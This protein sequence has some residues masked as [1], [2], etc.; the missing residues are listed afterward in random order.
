MATG[1]FVGKGFTGG[2]MVVESMQRSLLRN[3]SEEFTQRGAKKGLGHL[4]SELEKKHPNGEL[5]TS[6]L[7]AYV[8]RLAYERDSDSIDTVIN[9]LER[10]NFMETIIWSRMKRYLTGMTPAYYTE[11]MMKKFS[12]FGLMIEDDDRFDLN[13]L[14][15]RKLKLS[16]NLD[17]PGAIYGNWFKIKHAQ[18]YTYKDLAGLEV[19]SNVVF[20]GKIWGGK[21]FEGMEGLFSM[22]KLVD[23]G[24]LT[25]QALAFMIAHAEDGCFSNSD[26]LAELA[27][28]NG[29][30]G[31]VP[32]NADKFALQLV[33]LREWVDKN[34]ARLG[35]NVN[36]SDPAY[37]LGLIDALGKKTGNGAIALSKRYAGLLDKLIAKLNFLQSVVLTKIGKFLAPINYLKTIIVE[38]VSEFFLKMLDVAAGAASGGILAGFTAAL[39]RVL[40]PVIRFIVRRVVDATETFV[41]GVIQGDIF[42]VFIELEKTFL[43]FAKYALIVA[44]IPFFIIFMISMMFG[45]ATMTTYS[46]ID[47]T[48]P[49]SVVVE[50][51]TG[52]V[53]LNAGPGIPPPDVEPIATGGYITCGDATYGQ[54]NVTYP[55]YGATA[56]HGT[57]AYW[58]NSGSCSFSIPYIAFPDLYWS[59][60]T[61]CIGSCSPTWDPGNVC[62]NYTNR[63][64]AWN[65]VD[66]YG[67]AADYQ[68][69]CGGD[70]ARAVVAPAIAGIDSWT[71]TQSGCANHSRPGCVG[72]YYAN[73]SG[74]GS[75]VA[76]LHIMHLEGEP[77]QTTYAPGEVIQR[78][79]TG[80]N[81]VHVELI[82]GGDVVKPESVFTDCAN[83]FN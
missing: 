30:R 38:A 81:H 7:K 73:L 17:A 25:P 57:N 65:E 24:E 3:M 44:G 66:F 76:T 4:F 61:S 42:L 74:S 48:S 23:S 1:G 50:E 5:K 79:E 39:G 70:Y 77:G 20:S 9:M 16:S 82:L 75:N 21:H 47:P 78:Y 37:W 54:C 51:Y 67:F 62:H 18:E 59:D 53:N 55:S 71:V 11:Q 52:G 15:G 83:P 36:S 43:R 13:S 34:G 49:S 26:F 33:K 19:K 45:G 69:S 32:K 64:P 56:G 35:A 10:G 14:N 41:K 8:D 27:R 6:R 68:T 40:K 12:Y 22:R 31:I 60:A 63:S 29:G 46:P 2:D 58:G 28:L 72:Y 80:M